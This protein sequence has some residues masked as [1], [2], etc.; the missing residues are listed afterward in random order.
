M[1][2]CEVTVALRIGVAYLKGYTPS[3]FLE[4]E[5]HLPD[6][7]VRFNQALSYFKDGHHLEF[8]REKPRSNLPHGQIKRSR[9]TICP[10]GR[11]L[12]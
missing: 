10:L 12:P 6:V 4:N 7:F 1:V 11:L 3:S 2:L 9:Y 8:E 5:V